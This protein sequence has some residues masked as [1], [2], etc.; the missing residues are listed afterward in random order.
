[1]GRALFKFSFGFLE[2][3]KLCKAPNAM[4]ARNCF[5]TSHSCCTYPVTHR[6]KRLDIAKRYFA[7]HHNNKHMFH[8]V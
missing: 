1:M 2:F 7:M 5:E 4:C 3:F 8:S 6:N